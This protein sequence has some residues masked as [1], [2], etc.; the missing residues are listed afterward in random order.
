MTYILKNIIGALVVS[1]EALVIN[2]S[3]TVPGGKNNPV[4]LVVPRE[5]ESPLPSFKADM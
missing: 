2:K 5:K 3:I 4:A 1:K